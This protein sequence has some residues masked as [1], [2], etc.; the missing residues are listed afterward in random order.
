M[1]RDMRGIQHI[2]VPTTKMEDSLRF[3]E[4]LGFTTAFAL[5]DGETTC[6]HFLKLGNLIIELYPKPVA[7]V[8][9]SVIDHVALNCSDIEKAYQNAIEAGFDM[10]SGGIE[11]LPFWDNGVK[12]FTVQGPN[13]EK[14][15]FC[16]YI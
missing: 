5:D 1:D 14:I 4:E 3:Y 6:V 16:Q 8:G 15:E 13:G 12:F 11:Y 10:V 7:S 9:S 2:G